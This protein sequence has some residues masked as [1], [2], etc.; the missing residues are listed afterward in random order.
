MKPYIPEP[1]YKPGSTPVTPNAPV[2]AAPP[3]R[4]VSTPARGAAAGAAPSERPVL[5]V[6]EVKNE[7]PNKGKT[8]DVRGPLTHV[9]RGAHND[10]QISD[11]S[12]SDTHAKIQ[13]RDNGWFIV[14][15][16]STNGTYVGG[17]RIGAET[18]LV[19]APDVRFGGVKVTFR[20]T[21]DGQIAE[22]RTRAIANI[23]PEQAKRMSA[24][25]AASEGKDEAT[26]PKKGVPVTLWI[27]AVVVVAAA[28][29]YFLMGR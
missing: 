21:A 9:G 28:V 4:A 12:V 11:D 18:Q 23:S 19:G 10:I 17:K 1:P 7:G 22:G 16:G 13:R 2:S 15:V 26:V 24:T 3:P 20:P 5:A 14:D 25:A 27:A 6:L 8:F 29:A